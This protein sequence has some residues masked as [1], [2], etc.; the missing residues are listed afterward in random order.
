MLSPGAINN[1]SAIFFIFQG[2]A[3][4]CNIRLPRLH[5]GTLDLSEAVLRARKLEQTVTEGESDGPPD[6]VLLQL[7]QDSLSKDTLLGM[8]YLLSLPKVWR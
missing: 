7:A 1:F 8:A 6:E 3:D 2:E 5:A 4:Y